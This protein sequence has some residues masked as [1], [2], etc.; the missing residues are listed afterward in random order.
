M[1]VKNIIEGIFDKTGREEDIE[2]ATKY[3][4]DVLSII[5]GEEICWWERPSKKQKN[6]TLFCKET[7]CKARKYNGD[8]LIEVNIE[9]L[10][11]SLMRKLKEMKRYLAK[12]TSPFI[13]K[14]RLTTTF[15]LEITY[16]TERYV[17]TC[18]QTSFQDIE[19]RRR[20]RK[21]EWQSNLAMYLLYRYFKNL[22]V[23][24]IYSVITDLVNG[25]STQFFQ[26]ITGAPLI[27]ETVRKRIQWTKDQKHLVEY[28]E[29]F[30]EM[31]GGEPK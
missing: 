20:G 3:L 6:S 28:A 23:K 18:A 1:E 9:E 10:S 11:G 13:T 15:D 21:A 26:P 14:G 30:E 16:N 19:P 17:L 25:F 2:S 29:R 24:R 31:W 7:S 22:G 27:P 5:G 12:N 8:K 4:M